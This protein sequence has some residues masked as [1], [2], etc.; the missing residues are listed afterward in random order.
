MKRSSAGTFMF[1]ISLTHPVSECWGKQPLGSL[2]V[3]EN[4][5][6]GWSKESWCQLQR[7]TTTTAKK[8]KSLWGAGE[9]MR[10][11]RGRKGPSK[12]I[13]CFTFSFSILRLANNLKAIYFLSPD[14]EDQIHVS[15]W[16]ERVLKWREGGKRKTPA[17]HVCGEMRGCVV[18]CT[19]V[20]VRMCGQAELGG[21]GHLRIKEQANKG[22]DSVEIQRG[23]RLIAWDRWRDPENKRKEQ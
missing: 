9:E 22:R 6:S 12:D 23:D 7:Q 14:I 2:L 13:L 20:S 11:G 3:A 4:K 17:W 21:F 15:H 19:S 16:H 5:S 10:A 1:Q 8:T 18:V